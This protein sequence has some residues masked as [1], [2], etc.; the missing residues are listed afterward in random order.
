[1]SDTAGTA[2]P[3]A[4]APPSPLGDCAELAG[5]YAPP[6]PRSRRVRTAV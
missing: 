4:L 6:R 1:M 5:G 3:L 2:L